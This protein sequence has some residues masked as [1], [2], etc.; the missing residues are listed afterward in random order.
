MLQ[1]AALRQEIEDIV[2]VNQ[3]GNDRNGP[4]AF[5][6]NRA[7]ASCPRATLPALSHM[8]AEAMTAIGFKSSQVALGALRDLGLDRPFDW[9]GSERVDFGCE[10][11][12][13]PAGDV[14]GQRDGLQRAKRL[15]RSAMTSS[16]REMRR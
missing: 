8:A 12:Q 3:R 5:R 11:V 15:A 1:K 4:L 14:R 7:A 2:A 16:R 13:Q 9:F 10:V 6:H